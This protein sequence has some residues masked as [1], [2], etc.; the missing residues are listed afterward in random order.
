MIPR[1]HWVSAII[2]GPLLIDIL[3]SQFQQLMRVDS[4]CWLAE[5]LRHIRGGL[6]TM[7]RSIC[8][9]YL[10]AV[11][12]AIAAAFLV[13]FSEGQTSFLFEAEDYLETVRKPYALSQF[14]WSFA[15]V[16]S[17]QTSTKAGSTVETFSPGTVPLTAKHLV[18]ELAKLMMTS[19][20][21]DDRECSG[22]C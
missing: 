2:A 9:T 1:R 5:C 14:V 12:F 19:S 22:H 4:S 3:I 15:P 21:P 8:G 17:R 16:L 11:V 10:A 20:K 18:D 7:Y 6:E 13:E